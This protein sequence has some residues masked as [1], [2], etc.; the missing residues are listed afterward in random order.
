MSTFRIIPA[1]DLKD[2]RCVQL[3]QGKEDAVLVSLENP[4][5]IAEMWV[6]RGARALHIIDLSGAFGG[7]LKHE[8]TIVEIRK[9]VKAEIQAG[10]GIRSGDIVER[11]I[12]SGIDRVIVGTMAIENEEKVKE[13]ASTY[14]GRIMIAVDSRRDKVVVKGWKEETPFTPVDVAKIYEDCDV[15]LLY[16]NVDVEGLMRGAA[17]RKI[18]QIVESTSLPVCVA[19]G[20]A[21]RNDVEEIKRTGAAG[22]VIGS[23]LYTG[24][25]SLEELLELEEF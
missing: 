10:G 7:R 20:I 2:G 15:S 3:Q 17:I 6:G 12:S 19:G 24:K 8:D 21:T 11:L 23:A 1:V 5:E 16:T 13:L 22:V 18:R 4:V 9:K 14:P 25:L